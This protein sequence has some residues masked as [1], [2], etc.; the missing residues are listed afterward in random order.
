M[1]KREKPIPL[2]VISW[3]E[4]DVSI[5]KVSANSRM[6]TNDTRQNI[7]LSRKFFSDLF[8]LSMERY[9]KINEHDH[10][11]RVFIQGQMKKSETSLP[12]LR[13]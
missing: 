6:I 12:G 7:I 8:N 3:M 11:Q 10:N 13:P 4:R 9:R 1:N 5:R 2:T